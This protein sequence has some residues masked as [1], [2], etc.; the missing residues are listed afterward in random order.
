MWNGKWR[1]KEVEYHAIHNKCIPD[2]ETL[3]KPIKWLCKQWFCLVLR[4]KYDKRPAQDFPV[5]SWDKKDAEFQGKTFSQGTNENFWADELTR[6][7]WPVPTSRVYKIGKAKRNGPCCFEATT[8]ECEHTSAKG[9][10]NMA[11]RLKEG[12]NWWGGMK[13]AAMKDVLIKPPHDPV[14]SRRLFS[15]SNPGEKWLIPG[16]KV[17]KAFALLWQKSVIMEFLKDKEQPMPHITI[18]DLRLEKT[19]LSEESLSQYNILVRLENIEPLS[20]LSASVQTAVSIIAG[21]LNSSEDYLLAAVRL[22][23]YPA[24]FDGEVH[25]QDKTSQ[26]E[27]FLNS[28]ELI[29]EGSAILSVRAKG[30]RTTEEHDMF[31]GEAREICTNANDEIHLKT[32]DL[33]GERDSL[34]VGRYTCVRFSATFFERERKSSGSIRSFHNNIC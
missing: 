8:Y 4:S 26:N 32:V 1:R 33:K 28:T 16:E 17:K 21:Y 27:Q 9:G 3:L 2:R 34:H 18:V 24:G 20:G 15:N 5:L 7:G 13:L 12:Q 19:M 10:N 11:E 31:F 23:T 22:R 29:L 6:N 30:K 14:N 25:D